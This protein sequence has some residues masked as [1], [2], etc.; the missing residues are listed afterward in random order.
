MVQLFIMTIWSKTEMHIKDRIVISVLIN[1]IA[2]AV[3]SDLNDL[4]S[5]DMSAIL[6][7]QLD[8]ENDYEVDDLFEEHV[9]TTGRTI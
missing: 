7:D 4:N 9:A 2:D 1:A 8:H 5:N 6:Q 3:D